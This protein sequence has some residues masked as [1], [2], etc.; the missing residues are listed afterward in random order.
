[1]REDY[2]ELEGKVAGILFSGNDQITVLN[3]HNQPA[4]KFKEARSLYFAEPELFS[5]FDYTFLAGDAQTALSSP[6]TVVLTRQMA[7]KYFGNWQAAMGRSIKLENT[8][9]LKVTAILEN[10]P[11]NTDMPF[12]ILVSFKTF[13]TENINDW[14]SIYSDHNCFIV[15]PAS[16]PASRLNALLPGFVKSTNPPI[17]PMTS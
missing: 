5:I 1:M 13:K 2:P 10:L 8:E 15:L 3:E 4:Q 11:P 16:Y 17:T 14:V 7:E 9:V 12:Q 6:N